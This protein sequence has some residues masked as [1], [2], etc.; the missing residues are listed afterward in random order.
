MLREFSND[1][2]RRYIVTVVRY[3]E[4]GAATV[5]ERYMTDDWGDIKDEHKPACALLDA[6]DHG[7]RGWVQIK[8]VGNASYYDDYEEDYFVPPTYT[9]NELC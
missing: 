3:D 5:V 4:H 2:V 8:G 1:N 6:M 7:T 9:L